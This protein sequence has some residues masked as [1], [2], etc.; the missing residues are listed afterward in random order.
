MNSPS[1]RPNDPSADEAKPVLEIRVSTNGLCASWL[2]CQL[3]A[4]FA[5]RFSCSNYFDS[6]RYASQVSS[7][8]NEL[9][10]V[11]HRLHQ[12]AGELRLEVVQQQQQALA[13]YVHIPVDE[14][15]RARYRAL[16]DALAQ[17]GPELR[18]QLLP[19]LAAEVP[20]RSALVELVAIY[21]YPLE[22]RNHPDDTHVTLVAPLTFAD[23]R[24]AA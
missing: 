18:S 13:L 5:A 7:V 3:I 17:A 12:P 2:H 8:L 24:G 16:F 15:Q 19:P 1:E 22:L 21:G 20:E 11:A 14:H 23:Q 9:L 4:D 10:E 6:Q